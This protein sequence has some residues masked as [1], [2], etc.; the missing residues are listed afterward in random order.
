MLFFVLAVGTAVFFWLDPF[1]KKDGLAFEA[2][3]TV[4]AVDNLSKQELIARMEK[5]VA[6][7]MLTMSINASP[8]MSRSKS[9]KGV[10]WLIENPSNQ[11][12]L[13]RVEVFRDDTK[14]KIY[15]TGALKPNTYVTGTPLLVDMPVG[16]YSCTAMFYSYHLETQKPMGQAGAQITLTVLP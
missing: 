16:T 6:D 13:I 3:V 9:K 12:K 11:G 14:E 7:S 10:N 8:S 2:N 4:G 15:E 1:G 5:Q